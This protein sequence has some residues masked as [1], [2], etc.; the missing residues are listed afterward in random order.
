MI[1]KIASFGDF[2]GALVAAGFS[3]GSS[4]DEGVFSLCSYMAENIAWHTEDPE[5][6][7]WEWRMRVLNERDDIAYAKLFFNKSGFITKEWYP[8]F[9]A[10]RR[11]GRTFDEA[12]ANGT[13][14]HSTKKIY[15][16]IVEGGE[17]PMH[18]I[19]ERAG[20]GSAEK[21]AFDKAL[22]EL[23]MGLFITMCGRSRKTSREGAEYGWSSTMF[24]TT[25][26]FFGEDTFD[27][28]RGLSRDEAVG[29]IT[30]RIYALNP[31]ADA[32]KVAKFIGAR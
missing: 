31:N 28:A 24:C 13:I 14:G 16:L 17:L 15:E 32:K 10:A 6:D 8:Y 7:P 12:Y 18:V 9:L 21:G 23:Q 30:E 1:N 3:V 22:T 11:N 19:K 2:C 29:A 20:V 4:N 26:Q 5:T 27:K 25:E